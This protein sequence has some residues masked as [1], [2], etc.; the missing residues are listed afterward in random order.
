MVRRTGSTF[1]GAFTY[2]SLLTRI[3]AGTTYLNVHTRRNGG[4]EV[5]GQVTK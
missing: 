1:S 2:D 3:R 5:R 4:G